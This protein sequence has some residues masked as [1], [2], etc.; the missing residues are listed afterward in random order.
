MAQSSIQTV[1]QGENVL[2]EIKFYDTSGNLTDPDILPTF[3]VYNSNNELLETN[4]AVKITLGVWKAESFI[5]IDAPL[6]F[7]KIIWN[8]VVSG[9]PVLNNIIIFQVELAQDKPVTQQLVVQDQWLRQIKSVLA[10]PGLEKNL[11]LTDEQIKEYA[12]WPA[13]YEYFK[14]WPIKERAQYPITE[15]FNIN[16][17]DNFTFGVTDLR[18]VGKIDGSGTTTSSFWDI[19]RYNAFSNNFNYRN[20]GNYGTQYNFNGLKQ[21]GLMQ[22]QVADTVTNLAT[23]KYYVNYEGRKLEVYASSPCQ[24]AIEWAKY[25]LDFNSIR[26]Q[27]IREVIELA[28]SFLLFYV[29]DTGNIIKDSKLSKEI[30]VDALKTRAQELR[31]RVLDNYWYQIPDIILLRAT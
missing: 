7:W 21:T 26:W 1:Y 6:G 18:A 17:P 9:Q 11:F 25:S 3:S 27:R 14:K 24:L 5:P 10:F 8:A 4:E 23:F 16:F 15:T 20:P 13:M 28:Q 30:N 31:E 2:S 22:K 29:A 12:V 19:I